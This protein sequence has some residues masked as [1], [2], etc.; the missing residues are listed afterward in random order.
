MPFN[1][2]GLCIC[3]R[4]T[5]IKSLGTQLNSLQF[6]HNGCKD[7]GQEECS[8]FFSFSI[9]MHAC[10]PAGNNHLLTNL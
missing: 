8:G 1:L 4:I 2:K 7:A 5:E 9:R 3:M 6:L 10:L